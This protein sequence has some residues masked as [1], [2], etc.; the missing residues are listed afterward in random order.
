MPRDDL[1]QQRSQAVHG[2]RDCPPDP[3]FEIG[4]AQHRRFGRVLAFSPL[5][6]D[7]ALADYLAATWLADP[8]G[9]ATFL[10]DFDDDP[11]G[12]ADLAWFRSLAGSAPIDG[13]RTILLQSQGGRHTIA[14]WA[15]RVVPA[16]AR[17]LDPRCAG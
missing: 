6:R 4:L 12:R 11:I 14:S 10:I 17:L 15:L 3:D 7:P 8:A 13:R 16:L 2:V 9:P 1:V 5:L